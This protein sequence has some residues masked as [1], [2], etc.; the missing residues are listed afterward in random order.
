[1]RRLCA[2]MILCTGPA[3][4]QDV[5]YDAGVTTTCLAGA[6]DTAGKSFCIGRASD[7]CMARTPG[8]GSTVGM[9]GCYDRELRWWDARLNTVYGQLMAEEKATDAEMKRIGATAPSLSESLRAMQRAWIPYRDAA[10]DYERANWGGGT[11]GG[12]ATLACLMDLTARQTLR[13]EAHLG[14]G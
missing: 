12:P 8:G 7:L 4:A 1:M 3:M 11:G 2:A 6:A 13:L 14:D 10:C 9:V 5:T